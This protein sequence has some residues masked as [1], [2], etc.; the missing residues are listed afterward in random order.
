M[1]DYVSFPQ[2]AYY[3]NSYVLPTSNP[4]QWTI[5]GHSRA[6][7]RTGFLLSGQGVKI[8]LDAGVDMPNIFTPIDA[9]FVTHAH[10]DH[11]NALPMLMRHTK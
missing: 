9:I 1:C 3:S 6:M 5:S 4:N 11:I 2:E 8:M 10:I 7:E